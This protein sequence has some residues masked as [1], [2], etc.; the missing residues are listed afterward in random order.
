M[1]EETISK[2]FDPFFTTKPIGKGTGLGMSISYKIVQTHN[3][4][5]DVESTPGSGTTITIRLP[6]RSTLL[7]TN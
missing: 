1:N 3:G 4:D 6:I 2:I 7:G 5:I